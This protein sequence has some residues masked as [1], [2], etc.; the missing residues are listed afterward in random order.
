MI[1]LHNEEGNIVDLLGEIRAVLDGLWD[2]EIIC[3]DD[4]SSDRT[5][6][7][8]KSVK[9][10]ND[11]LRIVCHAR[12]CGQ[13][14][15]LM[16][17]VLFAK[18]TWIV[19]LDGDGQNDPQDIPKLLAVL[20]DSD[21]SSPIEMVIGWRQQRRDRALKRWASRWANRIR[22]AILHDNVPDVGCGLKVL[23]R[24]AFL[25][26]PCFDHMHRFLPT[27][28]NRHGG[29]VA[30]VPIRHRPRLHGDSK[31]GVWDRFLVGVLDIFGVWWLRQRGCQTRREEFE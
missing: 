28:I 9:Q 23:S 18:K 25:E 1:P 2:Y 20:K 11:R 31:Y 12:C 5:L 10:H 3:V 16:S 14:A 27:L 4:A 17:G 21:P 7:I 29:E 24:S 13:S 15:A 8:L 30:V 26:L 22:C 6:E 19:T